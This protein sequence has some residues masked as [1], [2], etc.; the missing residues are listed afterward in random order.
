VSG[1]EQGVAATPEI[2]VVHG[3][4]TAEEI[5]VVT[6]VLAATVAAS[7]SR[8]SNDRGSDH[9]RSGWTSR[10]RAIGAPMRPGPGRWRASAFPQV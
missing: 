2:R 6:A 3:N 4:P 8:S 1:A 5:A 9:R 10:E 7:A